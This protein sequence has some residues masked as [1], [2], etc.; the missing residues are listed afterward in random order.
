MHHP[1]TTS[2]GIK[3]PEWLDQAPVEASSCLEELLL[4]RKHQES[5]KLI[6]RVRAFSSNLGDAANLGSGV[7]HIFDRVDEMSEGLAHRL[8]AEISDTASLTVWGHHEHKRNYALLIGLGHAEGAAAAYVKERSALIRRSLRKV[9]VTA[10]PLSYVS[11]LSGMFFGQ[12]MDALTSFIKL[13]CGS[14]RAH[15]RR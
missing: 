15:Q 14:A 7:K 10:D 6:R 1:S 2:R 12:V 8:L 4:E 5:T 3:L 9:E 13:F 11:A